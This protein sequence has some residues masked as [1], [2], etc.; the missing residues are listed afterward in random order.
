[1]KLC[2]PTNPFW[3]YA[4]FVLIAPLLITSSLSDH[5]FIRLAAYCAIVVGL[6]AISLWYACKYNLESYITDNAPIVKK[7]GKRKIAYVWRMLLIVFA[8]LFALP[9]LPNLIKD[10]AYVTQNHMP[11]HSIGVVEGKKA[12]AFT[13]L[14]YQRLS[15]SIGAESGSFGAFE[16]PLNFFKIGSKYEITYLPN[17]KIILQARLSE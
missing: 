16:F 3:Y 8:V 2:I 14:F 13:S 17:S 10:T 11:A 9:L 1:M 5:W 4:F 6:P 15:M 7:Y 12:N